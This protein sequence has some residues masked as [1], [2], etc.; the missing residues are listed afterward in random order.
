MSCVFT[1]CRGLK[2][3]TGRYNRIEGDQSV[4]HIRW[5]KDGYWWPVAVRTEN[6][7]E[8]S[9]WFE[10]ND[11]IR[12]L[13]KTI[14]AIQLKVNGQEG[15]SFIIN[16][17]GQVIMP[18]ALEW[19]QRYFVGTLSGEWRLLTPDG[20][21]V[22]LGDARELKCGAP[23]PL[24]YVG[25]PYNL[26]GGDR[27]YFQDAAP[28]GERILYPASEDHDLIRALRRIRRWGPVRFIVNP[29][30]V[31]LTKRPR[32]GTDEEA[33]WEPVYVGR[34]DFRYWFPKEDAP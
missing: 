2:P 8:E 11:A 12:R 18:S 19:R 30:G 28:E 33:Q 9:Y 29:F 13:T 23:W 34:I 31:V 7:V 10:Q 27:I 16:E 22:S 14:C 32:R 24:P 5:H 15:G 21:S 26:S 17:W 25:V 1:P 4:F 6:F 3:W 20:E